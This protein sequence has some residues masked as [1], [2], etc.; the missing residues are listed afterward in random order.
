MD[1]D[2]DEK[3]PYRPVMW[4]CHDIACRFAFLAVETE[5]L[6]TISELS[7]IMERAKF[8]VQQEIDAWV[9][10]IIHAGSNT[11]AN[12]T[13][14]AEIA[15]TGSSATL[16]PY[17]YFVVARCLIQVSWHFR[18]AKQLRDALLT[19]ALADRRKWSNTLRERFPQLHHLNDVTDNEWD[20]LSPLR[21]WDLMARVW[22]GAQYAD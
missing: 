13:I 22:N 9:Y 10:R 15:A 14:S 6:A 5:A 20:Q 1:C 16:P 17:G 18:S 7:G 3:P 4:N 8:V 11:L 2:L 21:V 12:S 19:E